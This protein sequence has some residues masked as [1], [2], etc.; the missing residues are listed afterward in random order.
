MDSDPFV[1]D[2]AARLTLLLLSG[3]MILAFLRLVRGPSLPDRVAALDTVA[4]LALCA[5]AVTCILSG[6]SVF[7]DVA[8]VV[9]LV[10]FLGTVAFAKY[11]EKRVER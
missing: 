11:V 6:Q 5:I 3:G 10:V 1:V 4:T 7:L 8:M 9:A 2:Y